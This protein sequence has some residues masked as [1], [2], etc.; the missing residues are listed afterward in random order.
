MIAGNRPM[1]RNPWTDLLSLQ[2]EMNRLFGGS[3]DTNRNATFM[4]SSQ[5]LPAVDVLRSAEKLIV[6]MDIPGARKEDFDIT[7]L[8]NQLSIRRISK[9]EE[10]GADGKAHNAERFLGTL[11]RTVELP[12][13]VTP[14]SIKATYVDGVLEVSAHVSDDSKPRRIDLNVV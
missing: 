9:S 13:N 4:Q 5:F 1:R 11:E 7:L 2:D 12:V 6:R 14:E 10:S 3:L 8:N